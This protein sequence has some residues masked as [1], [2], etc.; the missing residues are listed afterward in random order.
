LGA[1]AEQGL[2]EALSGERLNAGKIGIAMFVGG[3]LQATLG[4]A[5]EGSIEKLLGSRF[6][7]VPGTLSEKL[8]DIGLDGETIA[9]DA[10][11]AVVTNLGMAAA[12]GTWSLF[13]E[14]LPN[15]GKALSD[16]LNKASDEGG[17]P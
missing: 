1:G 7:Q 9:L 5:M 13:E 3:A 14:K 4:R 17:N 11:L 10:A 16:P 12:E 15:M 2:K 8:S 6:G